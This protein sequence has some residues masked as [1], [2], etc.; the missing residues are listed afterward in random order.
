[1]FLHCFMMSIIEHIAFTNLDKKS[2]QDNFNQSC[3]INSYKLGISVF[4]KDVT[5]RA[6]VTKRMCQNR[7]FLERQKNSLFSAATNPVQNQSGC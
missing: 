2:I 7:S 4:R 6:Q 5:A 1:M 3:M